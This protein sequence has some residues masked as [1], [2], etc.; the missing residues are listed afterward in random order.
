MYARWMRMFP[1]LVALCVLLSASF[2][3][4]AAQ[5]KP[6]GNPQ[7]SQFAGLAMPGGPLE[8]IVYENGSLGLTEAGYNQFYDA[9]A[10]GV[11]LWVNGVVY[12]PNVPAGNMMNSYTLISQRGPEGSGTL[13]DP[14]RITTEFT[15][16]TTG[17]NLQQVVTYVNGSRSMDFSWVVTLGARALP[18]TLFHA[19]DLYVDGDDYGTG[20]FDDRTR[21]VGGVSRDSRFYGTFL[22]ITPATAYEEG[23]YA[24]IW[25]R[26]GNA[27]GIGEGFRNIIVPDYIDNAAG[28]QW[29][30]PVTSA[31]TSYAI[32]SRY[33][34]M[35]DAGSSSN[36]SL[37]VPPLDAHRQILP[38]L[39]EFQ[40]GNQVSTSPT[41][42]RSGRIEFNLPITRYYGYFGNNNEYF[43][44]LVDQTAYLTL[45]VFDV[46][47]QERNRVRV[48]GCTLNVALT[49]SHNSWRDVTLPV[50]ATCLNFP[51]APSLPN[52][53]DTS[54][55]PSSTRI[56]PANN[57]IIVEIDLDNRGYRAQVAWAKL[58][59]GGVRPVLYI[60]GFDPSCAGNRT[61]ALGQIRNF[62]NADGIPNLG[63]RNDGA[64]YIA[65]QVGDVELAY[66]EMQRI[67][68][69][70]SMSASN[71]AEPDRIL[72]LGHS[73]GGLTGRRFINLQHSAGNPIVE[74]FVALATPNQGS[75]LAGAANNFLDFGRGCND[76]ASHDLSEDHVRNTFNPDN[77][78]QYSWSRWSQYGGSTSSD[79]HISSVA[80]VE[81]LS[82]IGDN[83]VVSRGDGVVMSENTFGLAYDHDRYFLC[84]KNDDAGENC[85]VYWGGSQLHN[86]IVEY[87]SLYTFLKSVMDM[88]QIVR[89]Q[90]VLSSQSSIVPT[91]TASAP[92]EIAPAQTSASSATL[93]V[94]SGT[95]NA[96]QSLD[97]D[98]PVDPI[99]NLVVVGRTGTTSLNFTLRSPSGVISSADEGVISM[100]SPEVGTWRLSIAAPA[101][102]LNYSLSAS[103]EATLALSPDSQAQIVRGTSGQ[104]A[105]IVNDGG[106]GLSGLT[107]SGSVRL[108]GSLDPLPLTFNS[109]PFT[110][111]RYV[112]NVSPSQIGPLLAWVQ[113][114][115]QRAA[116][117]AFTR[118]LL[119]SAQAISGGIIY[120]DPP[121][122]ATQDLDGNGLF[123]KLN[124]SIQIDLPGAGNYQVSAA[125]QQ[126]DNG[127]TI[128]VSQ[129]VFSGTA[130]VRPLTLSFDGSYLGALGLNTLVRLT[131]VTV[132][133]EAGAVL[134]VRSQLGQ[135]FTLNSGEFQRSLI[136]AQ[137][138]TG[139][140]VDSNSDGRFDELV[141]TGS[142][143]S[144]VADSF[145]VE[146]TLIDRNGQPFSFSE[147]GMM[148]N[149]GVNSLRIAFRGL[150]IAAHGQSG[151]FTLS[152]LV[153]SP[154][155]SDVIEP[156]RLNN[157]F[158]TAA[159]N[160]AVFGNAARLNLISNIGAERAFIRVSP[161]ALDGIYPQGVQVSVEAVIIDQSVTFAG[162]RV[163]GQFYTTTTLD[164]TLSSDLT[165]EAI[166]TQRVFLPLIWR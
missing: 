153:I 34:V 90:Q 33:S 147:Q 18:F 8:I 107:V 52:N 162:W 165:V 79:Q 63:A 148:L 64:K 6:K 98:F 130:G 57:T 16:G 139:A 38:G 20:F 142:I 117:Q 41:S 160:S 103:A 122:I 118:E 23:F 82:Q 123:D 14:W 115:G 32:R 113:V 78:L 65:T 135:E 12:G 150:D 96:G 124:T 112:A 58:T 36:D 138:T 53:L 116:G 56:T 144:E 104:L 155:N 100:S 99:S 37:E 24:T 121:V 4:Q 59:V 71:V 76:E 45:R 84:K 77:N 111:A 48:N 145:T 54:D 15:V 119:L 127:Q 51:N 2:P 141:F 27:A 44:N 30:Y 19:A 50:P 22:P 157:V 66:E 140:P 97:Y 13:T 74:R 152:N 68:G 72:L 43:A 3:V 129:E 26:I 70:R 114:S 131:Q 134:D 81:V 159:I 161:A 108:P 28:L 110:S 91:A 29:S 46:D 80:A 102:T 7:L 93:F 88:G 154:Q 146:A 126:V 60:H 151:V 67:Y 87:R 101:Q 25:D 95:L 158:S 40:F 17:I 42:Y 156:L 49:G 9:Q 109:D 5:P 10:S 73:M 31:N 94:R 125:L 61:R 21:A 132:A 47:S 83:Y 137:I 149:P 35:L 166:F 120:P 92:T 69:L 86:T 133:N 143:R 11:F 75:S 106:A 1:L 39:R 62:L 128:A 55:I 164:V 105:V 89:S 163:N 85:K 136:E